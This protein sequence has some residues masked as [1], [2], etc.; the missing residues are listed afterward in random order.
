MAE[1]EITLPTVQYGNVKVRMTPEEMGISSIADADVLGTAAAV[2]LNL[3]SQ[4]FKVGA[5]MDV[6]AP[7]KPSQGATVEQA[8]RMLDEGLGGVTE[9]PG[10]GGVEGDG[11][12]NEAK[13]PWTEPAVDSQPKPWETGTNTPDK[14]VVALGDGW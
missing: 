10:Y 12:F 9:V 4:G 1:I 11:L 6:S 5:A 13:A 14:A 8:K 2:Y 3:F 7:E